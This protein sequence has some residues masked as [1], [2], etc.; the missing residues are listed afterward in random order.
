M[1]SSMKQS[2][3]PVAVTGIWTAIGRPLA[4]AMVRSRKTGA[5]AVCCIG[6]LVTDG[7]QDLH[8]GISL[9]RNVTISEKAHHV[10]GFGDPPNV[11][12][13]AT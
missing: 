3:R 9:L 4:I 13:S 7:S 11:S 5:G 6:L 12:R 10:G 8:N 1:M 2:E